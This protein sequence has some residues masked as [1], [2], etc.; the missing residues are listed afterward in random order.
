VV[1]YIRYVDAERAQKRMFHCTDCFAWGSLG[2][3]AQLTFVA[4]YR[5][6]L[7]LEELLAVR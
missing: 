3:L 2:Q 7:H 4:L 1:R 5:L 6:K